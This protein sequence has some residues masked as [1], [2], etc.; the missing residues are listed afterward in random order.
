MINGSGG[1]LNRYI[2]VSDGYTLLNPF[3]MKQPLALFSPESEP[4]E[5]Y[6]LI[7]FLWHV[8]YNKKS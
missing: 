2:Y 7:V 1:C 5:I 4:E 8:N 3:H 6:K